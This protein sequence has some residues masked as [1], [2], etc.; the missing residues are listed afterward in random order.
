MPIVGL[1]TVDAAGVNR[2]H[3]IGRVKGPLVVVIEI[4]YEQIVTRQRSDPAVV[5]PVTTGESG[6]FGRVVA[7][8]VIAIQEVPQ[9]K[10]DTRVVTRIGM[11]EEEGSIAG[12]EVDERNA[13]FAGK[14]HPTSLRRCG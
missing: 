1:E 9:R 11:S 3:R 6:K 4:R 14:Q 2:V 5:G 10:A 12:S 13:T 7:I 8:V